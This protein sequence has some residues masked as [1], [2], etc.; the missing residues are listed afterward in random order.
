MDI[1]R[2]YLDTLV[3]LNRIRLAEYGLYEVY[4]LEVDKERNL[5]FYDTGKYQLI[6]LPKGQIDDLRT[7]GNGKGRGPAEFGNPFDLK[8]DKKGDIWLADV[9]RM[10]VQ[11]WGPKGDFI[12]SFQID[13]YARPS[14]LAVTDLGN[15][16]ILS[17]QYTPEGIIYKYTSKGEKIISFQ[18]PEVRD[19]RSVLYFEGDMQVLGEELIISGRVKPYLRRYTTNGQLKYST[20]IVGF[21]N[22]DNILIH[23]KR[24]RSRNKE[25]I[26]ATIDIEVYDNI[27]YTG[28]SNRIDRWIRIIDLYKPNGEYKSSIHLKNPARNFSVYGNKVFTLEYNYDNDEIYL[29]EYEVSRK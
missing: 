20:G 15:I 7:I 28:I 16:Y 27:I 19:Y 22:I 29:G 18:K 21:K 9:E 12:Q 11:Q 17:E 25:L 8:F 2:V 24:W 23:E 26:R 1:E 5:V 13:K 4:F 14:K 3:N 10:E 6:Y